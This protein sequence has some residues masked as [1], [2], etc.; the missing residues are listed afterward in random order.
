MFHKLAVLMKSNS[1]THTPSPVLCKVYSV[2]SRNNVYH[3][4]E[5]I[6]YMLCFTNTKKY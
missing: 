1:G 3:K 5:S 4:T 2:A 6:H